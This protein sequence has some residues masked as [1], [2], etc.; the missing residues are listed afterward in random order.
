MPFSYLINLHKAISM[1]EFVISVYILYVISLALFLFYGRPFRCNFNGWKKYR[2]YG[3][4]NVWWSHARYDV[5]KCDWL[6]KCTSLGWRFI[7]VDWTDHTTPKQIALSMSVVCFFL[8]F[9]EI[10]NENVNFFCYLALFSVFPD[11]WPLFSVA[12]LFWDAI[13]MFCLLCRCSVFIW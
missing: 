2:N 13:V 8:P 12:L 10:S 9:I 1:R 7:S 6:P 5:C 4:K 3:R 11:Y